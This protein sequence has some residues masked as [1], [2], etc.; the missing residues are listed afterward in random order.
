LVNNFGFSVSGRVHIRAVTPKPSR[1]FV[2]VNDSPL[3]SQQS[4][5]N[6]T[7]CLTDPQR[8]L[9]CICMSA[10]R[11]RIIELWGVAG[12]PSGGDMLYLGFSDSRDK[13]NPP[14]KTLFYSNTLFCSPFYWL[15]LRLQQDLGTESGCPF[16][17]PQL[18]VYQYLSIAAHSSQANSHSLPT[19]SGEIYPTGRFSLFTNAFPSPLTRTRQTL[20]LY[21]C[22][23]Q[24]CIQ[25]A[26]THSLPMSFSPHIRASNSHSLPTF[27][28]ETTRKYSFF[29]NVFGS[30]VSPT[31]KHSPFTNVF[32][33]P[34]SSRQSSPGSAPKSPTWST[35]FNSFLFY[36]IFSKSRDHASEPIRP[37]SSFR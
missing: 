29:T 7:K 36:S 10:M 25:P 31:H 26:N 1:M 6:P 16:Q 9:Y 27:S 14:R 24:P 22:F 20:T 18:A 35:L 34:V 19:F 3:D 2:Y 12:A 28:A 8:G 37:D 30:R 15:L 32:N 11:T 23:P 5:K 21:R 4:S 13:D 17:P 33:E